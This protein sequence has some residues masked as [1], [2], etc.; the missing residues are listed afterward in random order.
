MNLESPLD[1][2]QLMQSGL[3]VLVLWT[4]IGVYGSYYIFRSL[5]VETTGEDRLLNISQTR[6]DRPTRT[7][8]FPK[9]P[10]E[11]PFT[12]LVTCALFGPLAVILLLLLVVPLATKY[13][14]IRRIVTV[15]FL[16]SH[17]DNIVNWFD[18]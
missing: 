15:W 7:L 18:R 9:S 12:G 4:T 3:F 14:G 16:S 17:A 10:R 11:L 2:L 5:A 1:L 6:Q 8:T 13:I